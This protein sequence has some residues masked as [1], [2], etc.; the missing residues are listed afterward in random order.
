MALPLAASRVATAHPL[1][2][3]GFPAGLGHPFR[4]LDHLLAA[5]A[6]GLW[7]AQMGGTARWRVPAVFLGA[8]VAGAVMGRAGVALPAVEP[9]LLASLLVIG[10]FVALSVRWPGVSGLGV[11][12]VFAVLHGHAHGSEAVLG[13]SFIE[14]VA[15]LALAT[16]VL[17]VTGTAAAHAARTR[18]QTIRLAGLTI[19][20]AGVLAAAGLL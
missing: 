6:V 8:M 15:G 7:A 1:A 9:G 11:A 12:A 2:E 16:A 19:A 18:P 5:V 17:L 10:L 3:T 13:V 14:Y 20:A 4:G